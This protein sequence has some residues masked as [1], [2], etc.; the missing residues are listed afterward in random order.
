MPVV[1]IHFF[2]P[3]CATSPELA[4]K[5]DDMQQTYGENVC[6]LILNLKQSANE[7]VRF[8]REND[9]Q[10]SKIGFLDQ[11][12]LPMEYGI[13]GLPHKTVIL[14]DGE[15]KHNGSDVTLRQIENMCIASAEQEFKGSDVSARYVELEKDDPLLRENPR[16][17]VMFPIKYPDIWHFYKLHEASFWTA[18]QIDLNQD[19]R[20]WNNLE[21]SSRFFI[22]HML[23][24]L[25]SSDGI[26]ME[27]ILSRLSVEIQVPEARAFY[28]FQSAMRNIHIEAYSML[29]NHYAEFDVEKLFDAS[30]D[31]RDVSRV[32][33]RKAH[34]GLRWLYNDASS[35]AERLVAFSAVESIHFSGAFCALFSLKK[36]GIMPGLT[37]FAELISRDEGVHSDFACLIYKRLQNQLPDSTVH[38][39]VIGA[40][41]VEREFITEAF[42]CD[43]IGINTQKMGEYIE[44]VADRLLHVLG[45]PKL[46]DTANPFD[47]MELIYLQR[48]NNFVES[49][50]GNYAKTTGV[51]K[52]NPQQTA[53]FD[54]TA[55]F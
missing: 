41:N 29:L 15:V 31:D 7:T 19:D 45:H 53:L 10:F 30:M 36:R 54:L 35:F 38:A 17:F 52:E 22:K 44:F 27:N 37:S 3:W 8:L 48:K 20:D 4:Q 5:I 28:S 46:Y 12:N 39:I 2:A 1:I 13:K 40:V 33:K 51:P 23:A 34:W 18:Q 49:R 11:E 55:D 43:L 50:E 6:I 42:S 9:I 16:R 24:Y 26:D 32:L 14:P 47:W 25:A 21:S